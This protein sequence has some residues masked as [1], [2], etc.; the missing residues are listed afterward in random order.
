MT[1]IPTFGGTACFGER[2][3]DYGKPIL[4]IDEA[5]RMLGVGKKRLANMISE[6]KVRLGRL[7]DYVCDAEGRM[8][9]RIL[10]DGFLEWVKARRG[11]R[12]RPP[13]LHGS[14]V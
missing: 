10:R 14:L 3:P 9:R 2:P 8:R 4:T 13:R 6:E 7:P 12:G 1:W 11:R 5:A